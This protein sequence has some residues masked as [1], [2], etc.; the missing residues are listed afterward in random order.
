MLDTLGYSYTKDKDSSDDVSFWSCQA[1][2]AKRCRARIHADGLR[3]VKRLNRHVHEPVQ[4]RPN[5][6]TAARGDVDEEDPPSGPAA[7]PRSD[8]RPLSS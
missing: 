3:V 8:G 1:R 5:K 7:A 6:H 4:L 2:K